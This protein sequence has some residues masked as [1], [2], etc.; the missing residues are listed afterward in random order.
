MPYGLRDHCSRSEP[1]HGD[2]SDNGSRPLPVD[3][4]CELCATAPVPSSSAADAVTGPQRSSHVT[5][6]W[7]TGPTAMG[8]LAVANSDNRRIYCY[9]P[10]PHSNVPVFISFST[11]LI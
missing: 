11:L 4:G 1:S 10:P 3:T 9:S 6:A 2:C 8:I 5:I 7:A